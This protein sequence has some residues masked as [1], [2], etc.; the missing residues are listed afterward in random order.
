MKI[1]PSYENICNS[2]AASPLLGGTS[3]R[4]NSSQLTLRQK[5]LLCLYHMKRDHGK[6]DSFCVAIHMLAYLI[7]VTGTTGSACVK[8]FCQV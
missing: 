4:Y 7:F 3:L 8:I 2:G 1:H 6:S 5:T